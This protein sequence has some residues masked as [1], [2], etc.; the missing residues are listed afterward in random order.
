MKQANDGVTQG[1][2][3]VLFGMLL[4]ALLLL[5]VQRYT[6]TQKQNAI[7]QAHDFLVPKGNRRDKTLP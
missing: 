7:K 1:A 6:A 3:V 5:V 2:Y 4:G